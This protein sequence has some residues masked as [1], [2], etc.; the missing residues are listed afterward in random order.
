VTTPAA[1]AAEY[2]FTLDAF[3]RDAIAAIDRGGRLQLWERI[4][5]DTR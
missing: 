2:P 1:F 5:G 3:Q 4:A